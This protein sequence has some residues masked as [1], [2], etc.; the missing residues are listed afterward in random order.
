[1][2]DAVALGIQM[3]LHLN[4]TFKDV[5][6]ANSG[7]HKQRAQVWAGFLATSVGAMVNDL[8][9]ADALTVL[10]GVF[11]AAKESPHLVL[12]PKGEPSDTHER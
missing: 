10:E 6:K 7:D 12:V 8:G 11:D 4:Q 5:L 1:M 9:K 3:W 2:R